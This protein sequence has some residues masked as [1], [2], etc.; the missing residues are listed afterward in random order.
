MW[1][2]LKRL[3][4]KAVA[5]VAAGAMLITASAAHAEVT[6]PTNPIVFSDYADAGMVVVGTV[7]GA[8]TGVVI[9]VAL[10]RMGIRAM[11]RAFYGRA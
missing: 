2:T 11:T 4:G 6:L 5:G 1:N 9:L 8:T 3:K 7:L 10:I